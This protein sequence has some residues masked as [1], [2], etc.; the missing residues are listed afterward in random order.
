MGKNE[1]I[2]IFP[3]FLFVFS[4]DIN[5]F[6][7]SLQHQNKL[8]KNITTDKGHGNESNERT[9]TQAGSRILRR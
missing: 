6:C 7:L 9:Y 2:P 3:I 4:L 5:Q 1:K 8:L